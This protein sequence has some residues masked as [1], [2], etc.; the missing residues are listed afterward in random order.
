[1]IA[2][3]ET[4]NVVRGLAVFSLLALLVFALPLM[5][6]NRTPLT[7]TSSGLVMVLGALAVAVA[8]FIG[9][10]PAST[11]APPPAGWWLFAGVLSAWV[12]LQLLPFEFAGARTWP[13][14]RCPV[15][16]RYPARPV[17]AEPQRYTLR[18]WAV[19]VALM[20]VAWCHQRDSR[21]A[22]AT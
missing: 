16:V 20:T 13:V 22:I 2:S 5:M 8:A 10:G 6:G 9:K 3:R 11:L 4:D 19:F 1:M 21:A 14:P 12:L 7:L 15:A 17:V 18:G